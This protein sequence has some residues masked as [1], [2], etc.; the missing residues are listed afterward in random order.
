MDE[1]KATDSGAHIIEITAPAELTGCWD[2]VRIEQVIANLLSNALRY[3]PPGSKVEVRLQALDKEAK[4]EVID[5]GP[6]VPSEQRP[7][8]FDRYYQTNTL[9]SGMLSENDQPAAATGSE[10]S[11][12]GPTQ[13]PPREARKRQ[14]LGLGLY[15]SQEIIK[16]HHG[17][18][19]VDPNPEGGSIFW[20]TLPLGD[21]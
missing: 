4:V 6:G 15:I 21:C 16:A 3:T 9:N 10:E 14:G 17:E 1:L 8:L 20:F 12:Q 11:A 7:Y 18:I 2:P 5:E 13:S 19:G